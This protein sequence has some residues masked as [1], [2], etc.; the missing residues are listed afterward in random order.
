MATNL[1]VWRVCNFDTACILCS[2]W[3]LWTRRG[4]PCGSNSIW[5]YP[6]CWHW[7]LQLLKKQDI[8]GRWQVLNHSQRDRHVYTAQHVALPYFLFAFVWYFHWVRLCGRWMQQDVS[9]SP[10]GQATSSICLIAK[11]MY[12]H[13]SLHQ[14]A[15]FAVDS[16]LTFWNWF[17]ARIVICWPEDSV[18]AELVYP[19]KLE[20]W[21]YFVLSNTNNGS[22]R[23]FALT[24]SR[25]LLESF[26][27]CPITA[28]VFPFPL[29]F[30]TR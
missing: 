7:Q 6:K 11:A 16:C 5:V 3:L 24:I 18:A 26:E 1:A 4:N 23:N 25:Q 13:Q 10:A 29:A 19:P 12:C 8:S 14:M 21:Q 17:A 27:T 2:W 9:L 15:Q 28:C 30:A 22:K 20:P